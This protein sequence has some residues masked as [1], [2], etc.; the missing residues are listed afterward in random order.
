MKT[1][2]ALILAA[3]AITG[4]SILGCT[5]LPEEL[6]PLDND[7][8]T[9]TITVSL[10]G[11]P[12]TRALTPEGEKT[13]AAGEQI[14]IFYEKTSGGLAKVV[15]EP[16]SEDDITDEGKS[17][18]IPVALDNPKADGELRIIYPAAMA[19]ADGTP[20]YDA[21][22]EQDGSLATLAAELDL[23][24]FEGSLSESAELPLNPK[25]TNKLALCEFTLKN[26]DG[27]DITSTINY[28]HI[29]DGIYF[30]QIKPTSLEKIYVALR[31]VS[32]RQTLHFIAIDYFDIF[33]TE[34]YYA[35]EFG[36]REL[37]FYQKGVSAKKLSA[38]SLYPVILNL[39]DNAHYRL[40]GSDSGDL[41]V[42]DNSTDYFNIPTLGL[43][44]LDGGNGKDILFGDTG[45]AGLVARVN[46]ELIETSAPTFT[47][48]YKFIINNPA[49]VAT[50]YGADNSQTNPETGDSLDQ[51]DVLI[52]GAGND[53]VFAQGG[54]D[55][56]FGDGALD[57]IAN[58][59][60]LYGTDVT[61]PNINAAFDAMQLSTRK[62]GLADLEASSDGNDT[63]YGGIGD[64]IMCGMGGADKLFGGN[65]DDVLLGGSGKDELNGG[66]GDDY[67]DGGKGADTL[68]G[69]DGNDIFRYG[70][71]DTI[72]G[73]DGFNILLGNEN[74]GS[75]NDLL[76]GGLI[77]HVEVFLKCILN[78]IDELTLTDLEKLE[79]VLGL[80]VDPDEDC[81]ILSNDSYSDEMGWKLENGTIT[82]ESELFTV[83]LETTLTVIEDTENN[84]F[85]LTRT[86]PD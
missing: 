37:H 25:L 49:T 21:L 76:A 78:D 43:D 54:D 63:L 27:Q 83:I 16:L 31:P 19:K 82:Y 74:D 68:L 12:L 70:K 9:Q 47:D 50:W 79:S 59:F 77:S 5:A 85:I 30:Y 48:V 75:L 86:V 35:G 2:K 51:P 52:G 40:L 18:I 28:F 81:I 6:Q 1:R 45:I 24:T 20:D 33:D 36:E 17:A 44:I 38:G 46:N 4:A 61:V 69:G 8:V 57:A 84:Q 60:E 11:Q 72:D 26:P 13:F 10:D 64:D 14:A 41:L 58:W 22:K 39:Q 56:I 29:T 32:A 71:G 15:S 42:G 66:N 7:T 34:E 73:E 3:L 23:C 65:G 80:Y 53:I 55:L 62:A 67:L